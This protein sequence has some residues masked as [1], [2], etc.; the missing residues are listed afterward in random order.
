M[1]AVDDQRVAGFDLAR[2]PISGKTGTAEVYG[3]QATAWFASYMPEPVAGHRYVVVVRVDQG[4]EGGRVAAPI[5][6]AV[7][8]AIARRGA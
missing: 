6:R 1:V 7:W 8:D 3:K 4:G 2:F 5:G